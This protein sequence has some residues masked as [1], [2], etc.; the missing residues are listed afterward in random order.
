MKRTILLLSWV[1]FC[2]IFGQAQ[3]FHFAYKMG[4]TGADFGRDIAV[5]YG[6]LGEA[7]A[8]FVTGTLT[9]TVDFDPSAGVQTRTSAGQQDVFIAKYDSSGNILWVTD[10]GGSLNDVPNAISVYGDNVCV[11][12]LFRGTVDFDPGVGSE[13]RTASGDADIFLV[14]FNGTTG[15]FEWVVTMGGSGTAN[16]EA[17]VGVA[18][19]SNASVYLTGV[20]EGTNVNFNPLGTPSY[21][22]ATGDMNMFIAK[23]S[24]SG[25]LQW[26]RSIGSLTQDDEGGQGIIAD[27]NNVYVCGAFAGNCDF[28]P[29]IAG[30][31]L[32]STG[33]QDG[34]IASYTAGGTYRWARRIG[35]PL[36]DEVTDIAMDQSEN[37]AVTGTVF[38]NVTYTGGSFTTSAGSQDILLARLTGSGT[39]LWANPLGGPGAND[40][41]YAVS[42]TACGRV[43]V[44]GQFCD[45]ADFDPGAGTATLNGPACGFPTAAYSYFIAAY[46]ENGNY[47]WAKGGTSVGGTSVVRGLDIDLCES[48]IATGGF[49]Q[50]QDFN[51]TSATQ[52]LSPAGSTDAFVSKHFL[53]QII[54]S[55]DNRLDLARA[56]ICANNHKGRDSIAFCIPGNGP[57]IFDMW[58]GFANAGQ[59]PFVED[60][61]TI[62]DGM[63]QPGW[64]MG[65]LELDGSNYSFG[66]RFDGCDYG[67]VL[68]L[69][70]RNYSD[71]GIYAYNADHVTVRNCQ[72]GNNGQDGIRFYNS[73]YG[74]VQGSIIGLNASASA[75]DPNGR[76][77]IATNGSADH[78][79]IGGTSPASTN[80]IGS[81][82]RYGIYVRSDNCQLAGNYIGTNSLFPFGNGSNGIYLEGD[83]NRIGNQNGNGTNYIAFNGGHGIEVANSTNYDQNHF[84]Q[85][86]YYCNSQSAVEINAANQGIATPVIT[87]AD[88]SGIYGTGVP[89]GYVE[90]YAPDSLCVSNACQGR[91][92]LG[93]ANISGSG[94]WSLSGSF[95]GGQ[96][97]LA[98]QTDGN[99]NTSEFSNC[100]T[101]QTLLAE[102]SIQL[103][104]T[105]TPA[106]TELL[107]E[108]PAL[109]QPTLF[110]IERST[111]T[112]HWEHIQSITAETGAAW[113]QLTDRAPAPGFYYYRVG[114]WLEDGELVYSNVV[115]VS[116]S[117]QAHIQL[118]PNPAT[119]FVQVNSSESIHQ[120]SLISMSG[121]TIFQIDELA[122]NQ[123]INLKK[124]PDGVYVLTFSLASKIYH[125]TLI[126]NHP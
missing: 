35:G 10:F 63:T 31:T 46:D 5:E 27:A 97:V 17:G 78:I 59:L 34:F 102:A 6:I 25:S 47:R 66:I 26:A 38:G 53:S 72:V 118:Y 88:A 77:G 94:T 107:W 83:G 11:T 32:T 70:I 60:D 87:L 3:D 44:G 95:N 48:L 2:L 57:H 64:T 73:A 91:Y 15:A 115:E 29:G 126:I 21:L 19:Y 89:G 96:R 85:N 111:N 110:Q 74:S 30:G 62:I 40:K 125:Q 75:A 61:Y 104:G 45:N 112:T 54:V 123:A 9:G 81:N 76:D 82:T 109:N 41:G 67:E 113:S 79:Q 1:I 51:M 116:N 121:K 12:G 124:I 80:H 16:E 122:P 28:N 119:D 13:I 20:F 22:S 108:F 99:L 90:I 18:L 58:G 92:F 98:I 120:L 84:W 105:P 68:G 93:S 49:S 106:G 43:F 86:A 71:H 24:S 114:M 50:T 69:S 14:K 33:G 55:S 39:F 23:Y 52:N 100:V 103:T 56:I 101:I 8:Y 7:G 4:S 42:M 65:N 37:I 36:N 117:K